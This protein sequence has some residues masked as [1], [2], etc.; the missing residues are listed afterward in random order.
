[1][2]QDNRRADWI[3]AESDGRVLRAWPMHGSE[4]LDLLSCPCGPAGTEA[5]LVSLCAGWLTAS[6]LPVVLGGHATA[7]LEPVPCKPRDLQPSLLEKSHDR[8]RIHAIP[9]VRQNRP[10]ALMRTS[11]CRVAGF[12]SLNPGW[13]GVIC[14]P[15]PQT[16]WVH[17]SADEIV[18]F[19]S[20]MTLELVEMV[21]NLPAF[22]GRLQDCGWDR[23]ALAE[24][25]SDT[26]ARP[27]KLSAAISELQ[28]GL[29]LNMPEGA[30]VK[31]RLAGLLIGAE[32]A[33]A[34]AYWLGQNIALVGEDDHSALYAAALERQGLP[35]TIADVRRMT[36]AGLT[37]ARNRIAD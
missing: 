5:D 16:D 2:H 12:L 28:A 32:L 35:A 9:G 14:L 22:S 1:M 25:V 23:E 15:G 13:D 33:A 37:A 30:Q 10:P 3:A 29:A 34:R 26:M 18:S 21:E 4:S 24:A 11:V 31:G 27:E 7:A 36:L 8:I 17:V 6:N 19:Q 20:F